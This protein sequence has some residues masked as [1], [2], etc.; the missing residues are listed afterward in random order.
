MRTRKESLAG[1]NFYGDIPLRSL[2][3]GIDVFFI[4]MPGQNETA[5]NNEYLR[6][7][8]IRISA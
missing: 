6:H 3:A 2:R 8:I 7:S 4:L 5:S 1:F